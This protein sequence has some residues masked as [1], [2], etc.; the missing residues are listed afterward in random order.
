MMKNNPTHRVVVTGMG[1][2]T[3]LGKSVPTFWEGMVAGRSGVRLATRYDITDFPYVIAAEVP[4]FEPRDYMDAKQARRMA[5]FAQFAVAA[6]GE[7]L[8]DSA[9]N[10][11]ALDRSQVAVNIGTSLGGTAN[12]EE[13]IQSFIAKGRRRVDAFYRPTFISTMAAC[14]G[15][16]APITPKAMAFSAVTPASVPPQTATTASPRCTA[17]AA[18]PIA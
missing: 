6:A 3:P 12:V 18:S 14:Q 17:R 11:D 13:Q 5:R 4:D 15:A 8:R 1:A 2:I 16:I 9:L 7:A 10:L